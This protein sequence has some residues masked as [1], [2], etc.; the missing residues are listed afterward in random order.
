MKSIFMMA[1]NNTLVMESWNSYISFF[2]ILNKESSSEKK[3]RE[4]EF[5][6]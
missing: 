6:E 1:T 3:K 2:A 5:D 4:R